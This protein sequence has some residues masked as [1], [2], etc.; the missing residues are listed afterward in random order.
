MRPCSDSLGSAPPESLPLPP[1]A[2]AAAAS[3]LP[4]RALARRPHP[5]RPLARL[6]P[7][8]P[9]CSTDMIAGF[10]GESEEDH[11]ASVALL[12]RTGYDQAFLFAYSRRE[13]TH[14]ARHY[15]AR[16][17][18]QEGRAA[19]A[20]VWRQRHPME[21]L[22]AACA[23]PPVPLHPLSPC[24]HAAG[25][26]AGGGEAAAPGG[27][28]YRIPAPAVRTRRGRGGPPPP[29]ARGGALPPLGCVP[30]SGR[31]RGQV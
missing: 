27:A 16:A 8:R 18:R 21:L 6:A 4:Q 30:T 20:S 19:L 5:P 28:D 26:R 1:P 17:W 22:P 12:E 13:K 7:P 10:C 24:R 14:A 2:A 9:P 31:W 11:A 15:E 25:R 23:R 29:G 3:L